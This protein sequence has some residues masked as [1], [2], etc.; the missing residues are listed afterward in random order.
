MA[1]SRK[2]NPRS[3][4]ANQGDVL[5]AKREATAEAVEYAWAV[6]FTVL[7]DKE[8]FEAADLR[9]VW[10]EVGQLS[11]SINQGYVTISDLRDTL[12]REVGAVLR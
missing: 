6:I 5:K 10:D 9:R 7:R 1:K 11:E 3:R 4:P 2:P 8:G 12:K